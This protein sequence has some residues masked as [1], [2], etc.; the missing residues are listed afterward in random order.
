V[1]VF[2]DSLSSLRWA[3]LLILFGMFLLFRLIGLIILTRKARG[4]ALA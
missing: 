2:P 1:S 3:Y 4:F